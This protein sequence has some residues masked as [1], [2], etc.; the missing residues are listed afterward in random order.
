MLRKFR[1]HSLTSLDFWKRKRLTSFRLD[2]TPSG[3][4]MMPSLTWKVESKNLRKISLKTNRSNPRRSK[5]QSIDHLLTTRAQ[6]A[7]SILLE[8]TGS[9]TSLLTQPTILSMPLVQHL[10]LISTR[11]SLLTS[12]TI[13]DTERLQERE[14]LTPSQLLMDSTTDLTQERL[15]QLVIT[16]E[17]L[18]LRPEHGRCQD[19]ETPDTPD[20]VT[21]HP[22]P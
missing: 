3:T 11:I 5:Q 13:L 14:E 21:E 1:L 16:R 22:R 4:P 19:P 8:S 6:L 15:V 12:I 18:V 20:K 2:L 9:Q 17:T 10:I 7:F